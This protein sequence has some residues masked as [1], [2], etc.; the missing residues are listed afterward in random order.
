MLLKSFCVKFVKE[1]YCKHA[2]LLAML[3]DPTVKPPA[4]D[5][6]R[7][8]NQRKT[9]GFFP[10]V[11]DIYRVIPDFSRAIPDFFLVPELTYWVDATLPQLMQPCL[12][13]QNDVP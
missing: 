10:V 1:A 9:T 4:E 3:M 7:V 11:P 2:V 6:I 8:I 13:A 12:N 5:D